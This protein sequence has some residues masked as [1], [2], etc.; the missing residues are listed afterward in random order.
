MR[1]V[2]LAFRK[3]SLPIWPG[4][5][6]TWRILKLTRK[7]LRGLTSQTAWLSRSQG[8]AGF[9]L[10]ESLIAIVI[11]AI[12]AVAL[13]RLA[14]NTRMNAVKIQELINMKNLDEALLAQVAPK[15]L[16]TTQGR[17][18][19]FSWQIAVAPLNFT[20]IARRMNKGLQDGDDKSKKGAGLAAFSDDSAQ[21][22]KQEPVTIT[23]SPVYVTVVVGSPTGRRY[24]VDTISIA[25]EPN[26]KDQPQ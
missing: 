18:G 16:G 8:A 22:K 4:A 7:L 5:K 26:K 14:N 23:W 19:T 15:D 17:A 10:A 2:F 9:S 25:P 12:L 6:P 11:A 24:S 3:Q 20:A 21:I 1:P 13:T